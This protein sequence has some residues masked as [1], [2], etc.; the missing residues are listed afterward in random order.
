MK[1]N[2]MTTHHDHIK[3]WYNKAL[4]AGFGDQV[5]WY[6]DAKQQIRGISERTGVDEVFVA[7][8]VAIL[9]PGLAW[10]LNIVEAERVILLW[11][12]GIDATFWKSPAY[13]RNQLKVQK[14]LETHDLSL[15]SGPKVSAFFANLYDPEDPDYVTLDRHALRVW[16]GE[17]GAG[18][19]YITRKEME[20]AQRDFKQVAHLLEVLPSE[21]Q[22]VTWVAY[23]HFGGDINAAEGVVL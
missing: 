14:L 22:A 5:N 9:S 8:V 11:L 20:Q 15:V 12:K 1:G 4:E 18:H 3:A 21:L 23:R 19:K 16:A 7:G 13:G 6:R 10:E 2:K 17:R